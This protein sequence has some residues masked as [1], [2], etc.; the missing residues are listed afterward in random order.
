MRFN[1]SIKFLTFED[2]ECYVRDVNMFKLWKSKQKKER[3]A[4]VFYLFLSLHSNFLSRIKGQ[5]CLLK[6]NN[7][8][9]NES[10]SD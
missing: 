10:S 2:F 6:T 1:L 9:E 3:K 7:K 4:F 8:C 5:K